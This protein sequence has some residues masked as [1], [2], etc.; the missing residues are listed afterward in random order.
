MNE[1]NDSLIK[2]Y[3]SEMEFLE[4]Y[5]PRKYP[6]FATIV[7]LLIFSISSKDH[8]NY[9]KLDSKKLSIILKKRK[10]YPYKDKWNLPGGFVDVDEDLEKAPVRL[11]E[12]ETPLDNYYIEQLYT[13]GEVKRDPRMRIISSSYMVLADKSKYED[14]SWFDIEE[15]TEEDGIVEVVLS[16]GEE[17]INFKVKKALEDIT[18]NKYSYTILE[19]DYLAFDNP[20][21]IVYG[22]ER[23]KNK[24][25]YTDIVFNLMPTMF[26]L[27]ELQK[28]Y[29]L[30]L[31]KR[32]LDP[33]FRR[34]IAH[35]V[36]ETDFYKTGEGH[37]PSKLFKYKNERKN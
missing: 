30:I 29:E 3:R 24:I 12:K 26:T 35:K 36:L 14:Y 22:L 6:Q 31:G 19:N 32:L 5:N 28:V 25:L 20:L 17:S 34:I 16:N 2:Q 4:E 10:N 27:G 37:R 33:A 8:S 21:V 9:K 7:D 1:D 15:Y 18:T 23:L 11:L 13:F